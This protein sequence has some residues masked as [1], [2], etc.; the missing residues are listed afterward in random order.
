MR[1]SII[2]ALGLSALASGFNIITPRS[3]EVIDVD[4]LYNL[5]WT[6]DD[7]P[8][9]FIV[10]DIQVQFPGIAIV[11]PEEFYYDQGFGDDS[12]FNI[13][14]N[15]GYY[16]LNLSS[17]WSPLY[18]ELPHG[19]W[20]IFLEL[21]D[22]W[23]KTPGLTAMND[24]VNIQLTSSKKNQDYR[25]QLSPLTNF[26]A[27]AGT[28]GPAKPNGAVGIVS[29]ALSV[30][31]PVLLF[32]LTVI[33]AR[34]DW[35]RHTRKTIETEYTFQPC[36]RHD[37]DTGVNPQ[38]S[39]NE[40]PSS[41]GKA[42]GSGR[43][44]W[45]FGVSACIA[46]LPLVA[47]LAALISLLLRYRVKPSSHSRADFVFNESGSDPTAFYVDFDATQYTT[48]A[49]WTS[50]IALLLPGFLTTLL[51]YRQSE[52]LSSDALFSRHER[53]LTPYQLSLLLGLK[54]GTLGSLW[55]Y[56]SYTKSRR[57]EKQSKFLSH[58][59]FVVLMSTLLG[60][61]TIRIR[62]TFSKSG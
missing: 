55:E 40:P 2:T 6:V 50:S 62:L 26:T 58:T 54:S 5:T 8:S 10:A 12:S 49:S 33:L 11:G 1:F 47:L 46:I 30:I 22:L 42:S 32:V 20:S 45:K 25:P 13:S 61:V 60:Y 56:L 4:Q 19:S 18:D 38:P 41:A 44:P 3:G 34:H 29:V 21:Y 53:L 16:Q 57:R 27:G 28:G 31:I 37:T 14:G 59:G 23:Q 7:V 51:W 43:V 52:Q 17:W 48:V 24:S 35:K 39:K 9:N 36:D 15:D